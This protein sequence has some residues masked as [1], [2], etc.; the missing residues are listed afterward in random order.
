MRWIK[1]LKECQEM[2][3][4]SVAGIY[5]A[6]LDKQQ[7][8]YD[9]LGDPQRNMLERFF[10]VEAQDMTQAPP[11]LDK[12]CPIAFRGDDR[13]PESVFETGFTTKAFRDQFLNGRRQLMN[14]P[15]LKDNATELDWYQAQLDF[16][17]KNKIGP[18]YR[19]RVGDMYQPR[20]V[21]LS[22]DPRVTAYFPMNKQE[23]SYIYAIKLVEF[24]N[25][26][27]MQKLTGHDR[28]LYAREIACAAV[29]PSHIIGAIPIKRFSS[30]TK[31]KGFDKFRV[32]DHIRIN[33]GYRRDD[34]LMEMFMSVVKLLN[35]NRVLKLR[36]PAPASLIRAL[37][38]EQVQAQ[39]AK[40]KKQ[41]VEP[42]FDQIVSD[43]AKGVWADPATTDKKVLMSQDW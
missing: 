28:L 24:F 8:S 4:T 18:V 3:T 20:S 26:H 11:R 41:V 38:P 39:A 43:I 9:Q 12:I 14:A 15:F 42:S 27:E 1:D 33:Q 13:A 22:W 21:S 30:T 32:L 2:D 29:L 7:T 10:A 5:K 36:R 16:A 19:H 37:D 40:A 25:L 17:L 34:P 6:A 35:Q 31:D 23:N